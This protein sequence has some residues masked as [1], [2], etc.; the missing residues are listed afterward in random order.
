MGETPPCPYEGL[1]SPFPF[2]VQYPEMW[3]SWVVQTGDIFTLRSVGA[4]N[5]MIGRLAWI[6]I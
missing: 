5:I 4:I 6:H 2:T 1:I 3:Q